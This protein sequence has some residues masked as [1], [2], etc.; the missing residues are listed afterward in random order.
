LRY[1][2]S[3]AER[4]T[5]PHADRAAAALL[6]VDISGFTPI[7]A[8]AVGRGPQGTEQ[9]SR[10]FNA[11]LGQIIDV[12]WE[13]GGD[14]AKIVGD[15][16]IPQWLATDEDLPSATR[17][18]AACALAI[19][20]LGDHEEDGVRLSVKVGL[21]AGD[22]SE[23]HVG[24]QDG[25]WLFLVTGPAL[26]QLS[27]VQALLVTGDVVA[28]SAAWPLIS[29]RFVGQPLRDGNVRI[30]STGQQP[31]APA[32]EPV[33]LDATHEAAVRGYIPQVLLSRVDAGQQ[34][35]LAEMRRTSIVFVNVRGMTDD[36]ADALHAVDRLAK[37]SQRV[38][39]RYD[40]WPK[41]VTMDEKGTTLT[42]VFGV[43]PFTHEDDASRAVAAAIA[44]ESEIRGLGL[45]AGVG[46]ASG[47]T[48]CGPAGNRKRQ[49]FAMLGSH[50][51]LA[52]RLMQAAE[53]GA[54]L[55][56]SETQAE[57]RS[58]QTFDRLPAYVLKGLG[59][60]TD[61]YRVLVAG[62]GS[63][64]SS[65]MVDRSAEL[66]GATAA[67]EDLVAGR[68]GLV[69]VEG[70]P[71]I[72]KS[73][74][75]TEWS[76]R[77][78]RLDVLAFTGRASEIDD[79]T[80]YHAW[81]SIFEGLLDLET[82]TDRS[83]RSKRVQQLL[84]SAGVNA[85]LAPLLSPILSLDL[86]DSDLTAQ[87]SGEVRADNT[88]DMFI[89]LLRQ[90]SL[91]GPLM[92]ALED[93]HWL[94]SASWQ[95]VLRARTELPQLL[96]V[97]TTRPVADPPSETAANVR[98]AATLVRLAAL[99]RQDAVTLAARRSGATQLDDAVA[100]LVHERAEGNP[101]F[102]EQLTYAMR[103]A[104]QV[105][106]DHGVL[107]SVGGDNGLTSAGIPDSVQRV[108]TSRI[109]KLPPT[110]AM[111]L[112]V[113]S[114]IG[115]RFA[116]RT[117]ADIHPLSNDPE[118]LKAE[119]ETLGRLGLVAPA[120]GPEESFEFRHKI[121]QEV[122]YNLMAPAQSRQLHRLVAEW[123][124][125]VYADDLSPFFAF[126]AH[127]WQKADIPARAVDY[128]EL[129]GFAALRTFANEEAIQFLAEA[130]DLDAS[131]G[132]S[133]EPTRRA[134]WLLA[135]GEAYVHLS[136]Y[137]EGRETLEQGLQ[138]L[139]RS[140]PQ[141]RGTKT[142]SLIGQIAR[143]VGHRVGL[144]SVRR[145]SDEQ[146]A[147]LVAVCR[148]YER[149][150]EAAYYDGDTVLALYSSIRIL[151]EAE[152]SRSAPE[153]A[154]GLAGTGVLFGLAPLHRVARSYLGRAELELNNT[155][156]A[157]THE[158]VRIVIG[159]YGVGTGSWETAREQFNS[160][161]S[162][163][164]R[165]GDRRRLLDAVSNLLETACLQGS[166]RTALDLADEVIGLAR[167]RG[168]SRFEADA[169]V[170][171]AFALL[172]M[173]RPEEALSSLDEVREIALRAQD[174]PIELRIKLQ[175]LLALVNIARNDRIAATIAAD[176]AMRLTQGQR[177]AYFGTYFGYVGPATV[178]LAE[179]ESGASPEV[180]AKAE[181]AIKR[182]KAFANVF[183]IGQ[184]RYG[185]LA[186][187]R[188]WLLGDQGKAQSHWRNALD[189]A[190]DLSM[191]YEQGLAHFELGSHLPEGDPE[192]S[193]HLDAAR[194]ALTSEGAVRL[195]TMIAAAIG[196]GL[197]GS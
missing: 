194:Q 67:L 189:V 140:P 75:V 168:D 178:Y 173:D 126:L 141:A 179:L 74:V 90:A 84:K 73:R 120:P 187:R 69:I 68:G 128:L 132:L 172:E 15:A 165:I 13:H 138:L 181:D 121:T 35:W 153:I 182:L 107:R 123:Y 18:A 11:Y 71:G 81:R 85:E 175:G 23:M 125:R 109:D 51:N 86:P 161:R 40:G 25:R 78:R 156:D 26:R 63:E 83:S 183:P 146:R 157:T 88:L 87:M 116:V 129:A 159:F 91:A 28:S 32:A 3:A 193:R 56:D 166:V 104:G 112:K 48:F 190:T 20:E 115:Q 19:G 38:A 77:A 185:V 145:L 7:T 122:A 5:E 61:V 124:E 66:A 89:A 92:I 160:V 106:I 58:S 197:L 82:V 21:V 174:L 171:R 59:T 150:A 39:A 64:L 108:I 30:R 1:L 43:P 6:L 4:P 151:N 16:L 139:K 22:I 113:A 127:H 142:L 9:L 188:E 10:S 47:P 96:F 180:R 114:V 149:L 167:A 176:E 34:D 192:R 100:T 155:D 133:S 17:R 136:R 33:L 98:T 118:A 12:I 148:A 110:Q 8:S 2:A 147:E 62:A 72:G 99:S 80:Q 93:V 54:V 186:G 137:R 184:P 177:P 52:A 70:D 49:D 158:I 152:A 196:S 117:L 79:A 103:D 119:L 14:I 42:L 102:I 135:L 36:A 134:R 105:V 50:V 55:C 95:L 191:G 143:Q 27:E 29:D 24:G 131:A 65:G 170:G 45:N 163:A 41:E 169:L 57:A 144:Y 154:R 94:D 101:L 162:T 46:I 97:M 53:D 195:M 164:R 31:L 130:R 60:P 44:L 76:D 37:A 111:T